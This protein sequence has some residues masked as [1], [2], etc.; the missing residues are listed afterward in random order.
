MRDAADF[1]V[2]GSGVAGLRAAVALAATG[3][4]LVLTKADRPDESNTG[5]AQGGIAAAVGRRRLTRPARV[6]TPWPPA[7][8]CAGPTPCACWS[9]RAR[10]YV[11]ELADW[12]ARVRPRRARRF[13][14]GREGAH[15][16]RRVLHARDATGREIGRVLWQRAAAS[17]G[18]RIV[19][20]RPRGRR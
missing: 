3:R 14:L 18:V 7:T 15:S 19:A 6:A 9:R 10:G 20:R 16:V 13:S 5:Y 2:I 12:G 11:A 1:L 8:A 17:A 4:V